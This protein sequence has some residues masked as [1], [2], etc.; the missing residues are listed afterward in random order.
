MEIFYAADAKQQGP[1]SLEEFH[2][3]LRDNELNPQTLVFTEGMTD[4]LPYSE[5]VEKN[6]VPAPEPLASEPSAGPPT[7]LRLAKKPSTQPPASGSEPTVACPT[8]GAWVPSNELIPFE[9]RK[10]CPHCR[11]RVIQQVREGVGITTTTTLR[12]AGFGTRFASYILDYIIMQVYSSIVSFATI[13]VSAFSMQTADVSGAAMAVYYVLAFGG[14]LFYIIY[15]MGSPRHQSTIGMKALK[16]KVVRTDGSMIT[17]KRALGRY[18]ASIL[19]SMILMI[20]YLMVL[21]DKE[22]A[23]LHDRIADTRIVFK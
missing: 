21:W 14:N 23:T 13:G 3:K 17:K 20:G 4:W 7:N 1:I 19:S 2:A 12:Y 10:V 5:A 11:D 6:F 16:I 18:L 9:N 22:K 15:F 8:C